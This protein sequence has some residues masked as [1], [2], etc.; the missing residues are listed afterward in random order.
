MNPFVRN[1]AKSS[2]NEERQLFVS[3][4]N[5]FESEVYIVFHSNQLII[6]QPY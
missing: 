1:M 6:I 2:S 3:L 5:F 4:G